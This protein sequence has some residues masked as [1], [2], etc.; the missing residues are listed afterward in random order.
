MHGIPSGPR[1]IRI[2]YRRDATGKKTAPV[3]AV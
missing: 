2:T 3:G 1:N